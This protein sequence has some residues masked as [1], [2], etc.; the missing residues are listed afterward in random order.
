MNSQADLVSYL[1]RTGVLHSP[2][3]IEAFQKTD[4]SDFVRPEYRAEAYEDYPLPIGYGQT[5]SQPYTVAIMLEALRLKPEDTVLD[6]GSGSG[7]TTAII[8]QCAN[9]VTGLERIR[10][11]VA[12]SR[13]NLQPYGLENAVIEEAGGTL[14]IPGK[15]FDKILVSAAA[16]RLPVTLL[17]QLN[18]GGILV[19]PVRYSILVVKKDQNGSLSEEE[20]EGFVFVPLV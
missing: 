19:I 3:L 18:D 4:R 9:H 11:L 10:E 5:I 1:R 8:A 20:F 15:R 17:D 7:W 6:I 14:G 2:N 16:D 13:N 12:F